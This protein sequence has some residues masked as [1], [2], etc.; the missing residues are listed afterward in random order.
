M[1][2]D[3]T[4]PLMNIFMGV[5][6][7]VHYILTYAQL[8]KTPNFVVNPELNKVINCGAAHNERA[9]KRVQYIIDAVIE[10]LVRN[11]S[12]GRRFTYVEMA[13]FFRWWREQSAGRQQLVKSLVNQG[14][15]TV[16]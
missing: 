4:K 15:Y 16:F 2:W 7:K 6:Q 3:G 1:T 11:T 9:N 13:Y 8:V 12:A 10:A 5:C 14:K